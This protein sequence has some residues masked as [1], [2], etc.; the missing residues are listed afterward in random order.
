MVEAYH[1][2]YY[3]D[4]D[5]ALE[6]ISDTHEFATSHREDYRSVFAYNHNGWVLSL[7]ILHR[8]KGDKKWSTREMEMFWSQCVIDALEDATGI[9]LQNGRQTYP[10]PYVDRS[11]GQHDYGDRGEFHLQGQSYKYDG[12]GVVGVPKVPLFNESTRKPILKNGNETDRHALI[13][14]DI[15][16]DENEYTVMM[17]KLSYRQASHYMEVLDKQELYVR[18]VGV[19]DTA[20]EENLEGKRRSE[21]GQHLSDGYFYPEVAEV[22][23]MPEVEQEEEQTMYS[24]EDL[25]RALYDPTLTLKESRV[26]IDDKMG[27]KFHFPG[28]IFQKKIQ[29]EEYLQRYF[30]YHNGSEP[31]PDVK[32][33]E[34]GLYVNTEHTVAFAPI[35]D[36][37]ND[38][39]W[40]NLERVMNSP[41]KFEG[42]MTEPGESPAVMM[43]PLTGENQ[44]AIIS[45]DY[46]IYIASNLFDKTKPL[47]VFVDHEFPVVFTDGEH[48]LAIAPRIS[49]DACEYPE[50]YSISDEELRGFCKKWLKD[51]KLADRM[52]PGTPF[53][54]QQKAV[55]AP[56]L[57]KV[58]PP[59]EADKEPEENPFEH[60]LK[61]A[62]AIQENNERILADR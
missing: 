61:Q 15:S 30:S 10:K 2:G 29:R 49:E 42:V 6:G 45:L 5:K 21:V 8:K 27:D 18:I 36:F 52:V 16:D 50:D 54:E 35:K 57:P 28:K 58:I 43:R 51:E 26:I 31:D 14:S 24:K 32:P 47:Q 48:L 38:K 3:K 40:S 37:K 46:F 53:G 41:G 59:I 9:K 23:N 25:R 60:L 7:R 33:T 34:E 56:R 19:Y 22:D 20:P 55:I 13:T 12:C 44:G 11:G 1:V 62:E 17:D 4:I 39:L